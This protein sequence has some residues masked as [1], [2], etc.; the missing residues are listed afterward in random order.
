MDVGQQLEISDKARHRLNVVEHHGEIFFVLFLSH[1]PE[2]VSLVGLLPA[3]LLV[4]L[5][6]R[7]LARPA[8]VRRDVAA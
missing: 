3:H 5:P 6:V 8:A 1:F 2:E 4:T 7:L